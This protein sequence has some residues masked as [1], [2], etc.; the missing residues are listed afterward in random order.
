[1]NSFDPLTIS[2]LILMQIGSK[3]FTLDLTTAQQ[4]IVKHPIIQFIIFFAIIYISTKN[5]FLSIIII[6]ITYL[7]IHILFNENNKNHILS[8]VWLKKEGLIKDN[9]IISSKILYQNNLKKILD[10]IDDLI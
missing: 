5:I 7:L 6:I 4:K 9:D 10:N 8:K 2:A 1:M 3:Y